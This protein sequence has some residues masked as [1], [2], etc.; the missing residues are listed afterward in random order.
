MSIR[1]IQ[2]DEPSNKMISASEDKSIKIWDLESGKC[3]KTLTDHNHWVTC[4]LIIPGNK[5]ISGSADKT[6]KMWDMSS[7]ECLNTF[8][9]ESYFYSLCLIPN[10]KIAVGFND[11]S[12][13]ILNLAN[14]SK[15][16]SFKAHDKWIP[17]L[18]FNNSQ[19]ISCSKDKRIKIW[20]CETF[21]C[22]KV[23]EG[24][25][26]PVRYLELTSKSNLLSCSGDNTVKLW[27]L[28]TGQILKSIKFNNPVYCVKNLNDDFILIGLAVGEI[29]IFS[30]EMNYEVK[31][32]Q[33][34]SSSLRCL[35]LLSNGNLL[36]GS[37]TSKIKLWK[38]HE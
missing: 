13:D 29:Q 4:I 31:A 36:S 5:F 3:L 22:I 11:G 18:L 33:A 6:I 32:I 7:Y 1:S 12:I 25:L 23:L 10:N 37:N 14:F 21:D 26:G 24:H 15:E 17:Y 20:N 9:N 34:H 30:L 28:E 38:I 19:L 16:Q 27:Q 35:H 8:N 2:V